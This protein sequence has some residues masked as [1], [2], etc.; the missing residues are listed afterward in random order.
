VYG[1]DDVLLI[2]KTVTEPP[3][4]EA[5]RWTMGALARPLNEHRVG[6]SPSQVW[7]LCRALDLKPWQTESWTQIATANP[8][9]TGKTLAARAAT[10]SSPTSSMERVTRAAISTPRFGAKL[11]SRAV[12]DAGR[13]KDLNDAQAR[14]GEG[15][16]EVRGRSRPR[17]AQFI[18]K[19]RSS[20]ANPVDPSRS[21]GGPTEF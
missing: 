4:D 6:I 17:R 19:I 2:V 7:R 3:P 10:A 5:T 16:G 13:E 15:L 12:H 1:H 21:R 20:E 14:L 18:G 11:A 9:A 8:A